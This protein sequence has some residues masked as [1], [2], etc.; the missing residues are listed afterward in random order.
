[1]LGM[2]DT[3]PLSITSFDLIDG[4]GQT[5][6]CDANTDNGL[7]HVLGVCDQGGPRLINPDGQVQI[8]SPNSAAG[9]GNVEIRTTEIGTTRL[10]LTN[11]L[12]QTVLKVLDGEVDPG[13]HVYTIDTRPLATGQYFLVLSTST[14]RR[15]RG[16]Q[17]A[18]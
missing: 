3:T 9:T 17:I 8:T 11:G 12:G 14:V 4:Q 15:V 1:M 13:D 10:L 16:F 5:A 6:D 18:K 2:S 7:F